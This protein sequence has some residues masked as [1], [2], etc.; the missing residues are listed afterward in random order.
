MER[1]LAETKIRKQERLI[2]HEFAPEA[3][4]QSL[5]GVYLHL[6]IYNNHD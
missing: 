5:G 2:M 4:F 6:E 3:L 1:H